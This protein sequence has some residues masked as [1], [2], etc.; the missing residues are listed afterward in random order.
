LELELEVK[1]ETLYLVLE[2]LVESGIVLRV[3]AIPDDR[4]QLV[5]DYLVL[6]VRH[7]QSER[8]IKELEK[9]REQRKLTEA[10][11][12][13][14][15][16]Q[17][18]EDT[19]RSLVRKLSSNQ[20]LE[21]LVETLKAGKRLQRWSI[22][23]NPETEIKVK[24][25]LQDVV[26][27]IREVNSFHGHG[28]TVTCV[29]FSADGQLI[30]SGSEDTMIKI[31]TVD[32]R[33]VDTF[34]GHKNTI[35]SIDFSPDGKWIVSGSEDNTLKLW[36]IEGKERQAVAT[37]KGHNKAI[38]SVSFSPNS[39]LIVSGSEDKTVKL[40]SLDGKLLTT[41]ERIGSHDVSFSPDGQLIAAGGYN[42]IAVWDSDLDKLLERGCN[43]ARNYLKHNPK[44]K[45][46]DRTLCDDIG[47]HE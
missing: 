38:T 43:W 35:T 19:R 8:L 29:S 41:F 16:R 18:L 23:V 26:Y 39:Q 32:G 6:F 47:T 1:N 4:Y 7:Q 21:A 12:N 22:G 46:R 17:Q 25:A 40:W 44:V 28:G 27:S 24:A 11:L 34:K 14:V 45:E 3:P 2:V 30:A 33:E 37:L 5:H 10:K 13:Q 9:E 42:N 20:D 36:R 15:L 31:W